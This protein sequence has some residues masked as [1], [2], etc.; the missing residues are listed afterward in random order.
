MPQRAIAR[1]RSYFVS[2]LT[3]GCCLRGCVGARCRRRVWSES[4]GRRISRLGG[5]GSV[6]G[7]GRSAGV[8]ETISRLDCRAAVG[9]GAHFSPRAYQL[10]GRASGQARAK[11]P[12]RAPSGWGALEARGGETFA[13][14]GGGGAAIGRHRANAGNSGFHCRCI[15]PVEIDALLGPAEEFHTRGNPPRITAFLPTIRA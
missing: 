13:N 12:C 10:A 2:Q 6:T 7:D 11:V 3:T 14:L 1:P 4:R 15:I 9:A 5:G 8:A